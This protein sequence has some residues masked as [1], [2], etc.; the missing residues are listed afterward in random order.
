VIIER[1]GG[2]ARDRAI[3][4]TSVDREQSTRDETRRFDLKFKQI[5]VTSL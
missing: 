4:S 3:S 1:I 2:T 5:S